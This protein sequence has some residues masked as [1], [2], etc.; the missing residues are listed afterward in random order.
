MEQ[1]TLRKLDVRQNSVVLTHRDCK[2]FE[3]LLHV[4][5]TITD[6]PVPE[7]DAS[8]PRSVAVPSDGRVVVIKL[9]RPSRYERRAA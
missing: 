8:I 6:S 2:G 4:F 7:Q 3:A 9:R 1:H 5:R